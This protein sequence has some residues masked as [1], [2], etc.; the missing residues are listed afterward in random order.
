MNANHASI[1]AGEL[2]R[3]GIEVD[4]VSIHLKNGM[5]LIHVNG[6]YRLF[7]DTDTLLLKVDNMQP[8]IAYLKRQQQDEVTRTLEDCRRGNE[9]TAEEKKMGIR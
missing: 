2:E 3:I 1:V 6:T 4:S 7:S 8:I 5:E 9:P